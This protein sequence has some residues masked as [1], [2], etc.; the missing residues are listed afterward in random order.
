MINFDNLKTYADY[1]QI[2]GPDIIEFMKT[3]PRADI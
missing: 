3:K 1:K 2:K